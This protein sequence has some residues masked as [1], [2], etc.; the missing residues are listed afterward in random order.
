MS[1][2][3]DKIMSSMSSVGSVRRGSS[4]SVHRSSSSSSRIP[5]R[6]LRDRSRDEP[7][8]KRGATGDSVFASPSQP[9]PGRET[10]ALIN[11]QE[12]Q[13]NMFALVLTKMPLRL[14]RARFEVTLHFKN[15][16]SFDL[17]DGLV[18]VSGDVNAHNRRSAQ[19]TIFNKFFELNK[20]LFAGRDRSFVVYDGAATLY[21]PDI[22][23]QGGEETYEYQMEP[24]AFNPQEWNV[25]S[26]II[27]KKNCC[28]TIKISKTG[29][30]HTQGPELKTEANRMELTRFMEC[31]TSSTL[32]IEE[33]LQFGNSTFSLLQEPVSE[34]D[35]VSEIRPGYAKVARVVEGRNGK[36]VEVLMTIDTK[37]S[38]FYKAC[39]LLKFL[40]SRYQDL[41]RGPGG[42]GGGRGGYND[43][44]NSRDSRGGYGGRSDSRDRRG[45]YDRRGS[46]VGGGRDENRGRGYDGGRRD[47]R[48]DPRRGDGDSGTDYN[49]S[50]LKEV[51]EVIGQNK[52]VR[53]NMEAAMK[54][55][56]VEATHM[57]KES[58][59]IVLIAGIHDG[60]AE[61]TVFMFK[62]KD[63]EEER[64]ISV[65]DYFLEQYN[66]RL[67][68]PRM[69]LVFVK[70]FKSICY[71]PMEVLRILPGQR[72][73][74]QKM[75]ANVQSMMTGRNSSLPSRHVELIQSILRD[76]L[77]LER[78]EY[79]EAFG[80]ELDST[81]PV[82]MR[83]RL[84][85]PAKCKFSN[86]EYVPD[87]G[88]VQFRTQARFVQ[89]ARVH[90][91]MVAIFDRALEKRQAEDF[92]DALY[93]HCRS[94]GIIVE[95]KSEDWSIREMNSHDKVDIKSRMEKCIR[96]KETILVGIARD[97][98]P[99]V[100]DI[101][102]Y[103]EEIVGMQ[104]I[105]LCSQTAMKMLNE[106]GG[107]QTIDNV[108]RKFNLKCGGV[109]FHVDIPSDIHG[110]SVVTNASAVRQ[111]L[112]EHT[113]FVGFEITH[114]SSRTLYDRMRS[115]MDGEP[116][117]VGV[118]YS[119]TSSTQLGGF[120]YLQTQREYKLQKL[121]EKFPVC[122]KAYNEDTKRLPSKIVIYRVGVGEGDFRRVKEEVDEIR[123]S[124]DTVQPGYRPEL[125]VIIAQRNSHTRIFPAS[126]RGGK[127]IEQN[128][129][130]G[131]AIDNVITSVG[132]EEFIL[133]SQTPLIGTVRPCKY[134]ILVNDPK[135][136][137]NEI[138]HLTYFRAFGHQVSY[139]PPS[140]PD[141]LYAAE[142]LAK[143]GRNNWKV[144]ERE[145]SLQEVEQRV[146]K[147]H[148]DYI[149]D[150]MREELA[151]AIITEISDEMNAMTIQ[152]RNF[153]A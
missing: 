3:F 98:K 143:R 71:Y 96:D 142:N 7:V 61:N 44:S 105:Q 24:G 106:Q 78:S 35:P 51:E 42:G 77:R 118:A 79:M 93:R 117:V 129:C 13:T 113:M 127:A 145:V 101:L 111:K 49:A 88:R 84:L 60:N 4:S 139:Q 39:S 5:K 74:I 94:N 76:S 27:R 152:K 83:A 2:P 12:V 14:T 22:V 26:K 103:Y 104:T 86:Q 63:T 124:F 57:S 47:D 67:K 112:L 132:V 21:M 116:S 50:E 43:R 151:S 102:K 6:D 15:G 31:L 97:K 92:C 1:D 52:M 30:V 46:D 36:G 147:K 66:Y 28:F 58:N 110:K 32:K 53:N 126:I 130:S 136:S 33:N 125:V 64:E 122:L 90:S 144:H 140:V 119:L 109:N 48:Y 149:D 138:M 38:P 123:S 18:G 17:N 68:Y 100:H 89:P 121:A 65:A 72:I 29:H 108:M 34:P 55:L 133:V 137:K 148:A 41:K 25:V 82:H 135:W 62:D 80:V 69:L 128:V 95:K 91:V 131:T 81:K 10:F 56:Y 85:P 8:S 150:K 75:T 141:I 20:K 134:T 45:G 114:G 115:Q 19:T 9:A 11:T 120:T 37:L 99:D 87:M 146:L 73:K 153:W 23:Y 59:C 107:R 40:I 16:K 70:R 54:G